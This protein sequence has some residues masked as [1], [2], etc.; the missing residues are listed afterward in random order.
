MLSSALDSPAKLDHIPL[1]AIAG[2]GINLCV[3]CCYGK[4]TNKGVVMMKSGN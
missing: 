2:K 1:H 4:I 3:L